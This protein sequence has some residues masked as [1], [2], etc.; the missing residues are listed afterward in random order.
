MLQGFGD[1][2]TP[3]PRRAGVFVLQVEGTSL[4]TEGNTVVDLTKP[5]DSPLNQASRTD[6]A[7]TSSPVVSPV[8]PT[9]AEQDGYAVTVTEK[10]RVALDEVIREAGLEEGDY[11]GAIV[12]LLEEN[13][14]LESD[15]EGDEEDS[16]ESDDE[17]DEDGDIPGTGEDSDEDPAAEKL[18]L[19]NNEDSISER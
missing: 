19:I 11:E 9:V 7:S 3:A 13:G 18:V 1:T 5:V 2:K 12:Y 10:A 4:S 14:F 15:D 6:N 17:D 8:E 16:D